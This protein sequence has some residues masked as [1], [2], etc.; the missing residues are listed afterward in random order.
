MS[1]WPG[2]K[3]HWVQNR[4]TKSDHLQQIWWNTISET[5]ES[6]NVKTIRQPALHC[7]DFFQ[8]RSCPAAAD[9]AV[10]AGTD[11]L[12]HS[13][14]S[15]FDDPM[16]PRE[17][18]QSFP[19]TAPL[20]PMLTGEREI[21]TQDDLYSSKFSPAHF[22]HFT[23]SG[24]CLSVKCWLHHNPSRSQRASWKLLW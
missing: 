6:C 9:V 16:F 15:F 23:V 14:H 18:P 12:E 11:S 7:C 19:T 24:Q 22:P 5:K 8:H 10:N 2:F 20:T 4:A 3:P 1:L 17:A 13:G 21:P